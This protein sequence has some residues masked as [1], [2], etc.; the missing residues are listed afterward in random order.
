MVKDLNQLV[1]RL[2]TVPIV[3]EFLDMFSKGLTKLSPNRE[4]EF[5]I[6]LVPKIEPIYIPS[7]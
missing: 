4:I 3:N 1:V 5:T 6:D 2:E 7:Y